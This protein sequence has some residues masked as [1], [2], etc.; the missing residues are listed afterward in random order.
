MRKHN[1]MRPQDIVILL[2]IISKGS[3]PWQNKDLAHELH[4]SASEVSESL[5]RSRIAGLINDERKKVHRQSLAEFVEHGLHYVFPA[6]PG[7]RSRGV[8][9][10]H[11]HPFM[12][13]SFASSEPYVWPD[14]SGEE[15]GLAI[16]P[17]YRDVVKA[18]KTDE[19]LY[20]LLGLAD[21]LR[22][23]S[24]R[25]IKVAVPELKKII[26]HE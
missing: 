26:L 19:K 14:V 11:S 12:Q 10:A 9:T 1:G 8:P 15:T 4:L 13:K 22:V 20:T 25:E 24:A 5:N 6:M 3:Q 18:V 7:G 21:V 16:E 17:L 2:K 23:G